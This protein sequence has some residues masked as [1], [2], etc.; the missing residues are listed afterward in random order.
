MRTSAKSTLGL[1]SLS[2]C[3]AAAL[4]DGGYARGDVTSA[5]AAAEQALRF[6]GETP[7]S[8]VEAQVR[9][10]LAPKASEADAVAA[11]A[12]ISNVS[13]AASE[14]VYQRGFASLANAS[15]LMTRKP[16]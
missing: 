14:G 6:T 1:L 4:S 9:R 13:S 5:P 3:L 8:L 12:V 7:D 10:A 15:T 11:L 2:A 16:V